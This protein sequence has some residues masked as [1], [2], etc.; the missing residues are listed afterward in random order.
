MK[1]GKLT[2]DEFEYMKSHTLQGCEILESMKK[3]WEPEYQKAC[4][5]I[6]RSH[7]ERYDGRG[8]P[9]GLKGDE[10]PVSAQLVSV[11]DVYD[12]LINE[13]CYK[14]AFSKKTAFYMIVN[15]G[16]RCVLSEA[17]GSV[18]LGKTPVREILREEG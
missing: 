15:G 18:P 3:N 13:R 4:Y 8:Y 12:A 1:P 14:A 5:E 11:A 10:I 16:V 2:D 9:D 7:H 17:D 6:C